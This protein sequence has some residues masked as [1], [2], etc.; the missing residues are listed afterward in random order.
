MANTKKA[1][2]II[3]NTSMLIAVVISFIRWD[4]EPTFH[5]I[6]GIVF[7]LLFAVHFW[8]NKKMFF[9]YGK[10]IRKLDASKKR[11]YLID[12]LLIIVWS[13]V[14]VSGIIALLIDPGNSETALNHGGLHGIFARI[15]GVLIVIHIFQHGR[16][17]VSYFR[18]NETAK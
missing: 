18:K 6:A 5:A 12:V 8:L 4:G 2:K 3:I 13:I 11:K 16:Q 9:A 14:I 7:A 15:G 17:I 1:M 10:N